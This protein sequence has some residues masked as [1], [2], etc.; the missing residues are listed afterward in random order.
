MEKT[1]NNYK[2][3]KTEENKELQ[4][5]VDEKSQM[6][7][8]INNF[9]KQK[10]EQNSQTIEVHNLVEHKTK[11]ENVIKHMEQQ[12][13]EQNKNIN[14]QLLSL[15]NYQQIEVQKLVDDK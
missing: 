11:L 2:Q 3:Q 6:E 4:K 13:R 9:E 7:K 12:I 5:L 14:T 1:I 8:T 15:K 10:L